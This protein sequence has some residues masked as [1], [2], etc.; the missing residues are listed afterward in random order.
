MRNLYLEKKVQFSPKGYKD[1]LE[2]FQS[3]GYKF[4]KFQRKIDNPRSIILRHDIDFDIKKAYQIAKIEI[5]LDIKSTFFFLLKSKSYNF[6]ESENQKLVKEIREMGHVVSLHFDPSIYKNYKKGLVSEIKLFEELLLDNVSVVSLHRPNKFFLSGLTLDKKLMHT[7]EN[8]FFK[9]IKYISDSGGSFKYGYPLDSN[10]IKN[11]L[12][13][14]LLLHPI[15]WTTN[16]Q[17]AI[18]KLKEFL[19]YSNSELSNHISKNCIPW[20]DY[21]KQ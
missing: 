9:Q 20:A 12:P 18:N 16:K 11:G 7:Y 4:I 5:G 13:M 2:Q 17:N 3:I 14:Q 10:A 1:L 15:W 6:L 21:L 8:I 19:N